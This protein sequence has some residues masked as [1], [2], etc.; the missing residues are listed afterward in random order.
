MG[1]NSKNA[2]PKG[3]DG[4]EGCCGEGEVEWGKSSKTFLLTST[5]K[6]PDLFCFAPPPQLS[7]HKFL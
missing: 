7:E 1:Q 4:G 5:N 6:N 3:L 2:V